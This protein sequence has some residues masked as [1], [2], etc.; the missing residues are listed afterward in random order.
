MML[1]IMKYDMG[2]FLV[3]LGGVLGSLSRRAHRRGYQM[4]AEVIHM[5]HQGTRTP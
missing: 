1:A 2:G 5:G 3:R 4:Q